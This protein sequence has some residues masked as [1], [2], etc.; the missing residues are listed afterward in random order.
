MSA[1]DDSF[2]GCGN[3]YSEKLNKDF[4]FRS[5]SSSTKK[6]ENYGNAA[7]HLVRLLGFGRLWPD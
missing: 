3:I 2:G 4:L 1:V 7:Q 6:K 5:R